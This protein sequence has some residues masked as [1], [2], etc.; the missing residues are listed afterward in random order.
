MEAKDI[1]P[2]LIQK[3]NDEHR[4]WSWETDSICDVPDDSLIEKVLIYLDLDDINKL[5]QILP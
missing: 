2:Y 3:L 4:F 1:R 5:F